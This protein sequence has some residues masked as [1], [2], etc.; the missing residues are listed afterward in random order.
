MKHL[1]ADGLEQMG[2]ANAGFS[3]QEKRIE[4]GPFRL[5]GGQPCLI[6]SGWRA[7][8]G[9]PSAAGMEAT[10]SVQMNFIWRSVPR[11]SMAACFSS[12]V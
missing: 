7:F 8:C 9:W 1:M 3:V 4:Q 12:G 2:F 5:C 10:S 11:A 6:S